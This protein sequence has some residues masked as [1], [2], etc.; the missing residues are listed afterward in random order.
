MR[1]FISGVRQDADPQMLS[2]LIECSPWNI[3]TVI[4]SDRGGV[5]AWARQWA[6][7]SHKELV[8]LKA[9]WGVR[10]RHAIRMRNIEA[11]TQSDA[12]VLFMRHSCPYC[13]SILQRVSNWKIP[14]YLQT[15]ESA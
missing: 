8:V 10:G 2:R 12:C 5:D 11:M 13:V 7:E 14:T 4:T 3:S 6:K 1:V 9:R 15:L